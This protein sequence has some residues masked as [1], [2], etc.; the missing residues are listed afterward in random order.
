MLVLN[1]LDRFIGDMEITEEHKEFVRSSDAGEGKY[2]L[3]V[4]DVK[5][6]TA[7][8]YV[9]QL[10]NDLG[11]VKSSANLKVMCKSVRY[12][13]ISTDESKYDWM[14]NEWIDAPK[15]ET[16]LRE[17]INIEEGKTAVLSM[18]CCGLPEPS[19]KW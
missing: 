17:S 11:N 18:K 2:T 19:V 4:K 9:V 10:S 8:K 6:E 3:T 13:I 1:W 16:Q 15:L 12:L 5:K 7:G 14:I